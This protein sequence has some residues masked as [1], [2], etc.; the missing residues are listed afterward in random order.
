[1]WSK[2]FDSALRGKLLKI[3]IMKTNNHYCT[4]PKSYA[5]TCLQNLIDNVCAKY[6]YA[7]KMYL[8]FNVIRAAA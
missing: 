6:S 8:P 5:D 4:L 2:P 7:G 3:K 1:M